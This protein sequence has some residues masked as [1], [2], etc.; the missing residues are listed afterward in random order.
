MSQRFT[1]SFG[2]GRNFID[3]GHI[4]HDLFHLF[5]PVLDSM[6]PADDYVSEVCRWSLLAL[7]MLGS[8]PSA[9]L[10]GFGWRRHFAFDD[11]FL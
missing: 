9:L 8:Q 2:D 7:G 6:S 1:E 11:G 3:I 4:W 10:L 5:I